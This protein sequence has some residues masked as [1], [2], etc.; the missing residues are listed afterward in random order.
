MGADTLRMRVERPFIFSNLKSVEGVERIAS[1][2]IANGA[3]AKS[4]DLR[5][6]TSQITRKRLHASLDKL[7]PPFHDIAGTVLDRVGHFGCP[8][9]DSSFARKAVLQGARPQYDPAKFPFTC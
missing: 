4:D 5:Q 8:V 2:V 1:F 3:L 7:R 6:H 9:A